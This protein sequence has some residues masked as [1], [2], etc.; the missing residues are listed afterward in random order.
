M[1]K[2]RHERC[3]SLQLRSPRLERRRFS[4]PH[5]PDL[6][7]PIKGSPS[8][9]RPK[10]IT[11]RRSF[12]VQTAVENKGLRWKRVDPTA[13]CRFRVLWCTVIAPC[14]DRHLFT[15][16][17]DSGEWAS[18]RFADS[19]RNAPG[20]APSKVGRSATRRGRSRAVL[21]RLPFPSVGS[22]QDRAG[23]M[24]VPP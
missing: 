3:L 14:D 11:P 1:V 9:D 6:I 18:Y 24:R 21:P 17:F 10:P 20:V 15:P 16:P 22:A 2:S 12:A 5:Q 19:P 23:A 4:A 7:F 8:G 13:V